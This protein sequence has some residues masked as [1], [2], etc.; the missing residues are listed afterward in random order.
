MRYKLENGVLRM[1]KKITRDGMDTINPTDE[2]VDQLRQGWP[3]EQTAP[4]NVFDGSGFDPKTQIAVS[5]WEQR[6]DCIRQVWT[7]KPKPVEDQIEEI[8]ERVNQINSDFEHIGDEVVRYPEDGRCYKIGWARDY[9]LP[10]LIMDSL[11]YPQQVADITLA[12]RDFTKQELQALYDFLTQE[13]AER[14]MATNSEIVTLNQRKA[15][16]L[17]ASR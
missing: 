16:L 4:P 13:G 11:E 9:Y 3:L 15:A 6:E 8:D 17:E 14:I 1:V 12:T 5:S 2:L 10:M 7:V